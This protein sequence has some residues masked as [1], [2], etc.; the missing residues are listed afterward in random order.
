V[1]AEREVQQLVREHEDELVRPSAGRE[2]RVDDQAAGG[3]DAH[4]RHA[5]VE[6]DADR[7]RPAPRGTGS[8]TVS[9]RRPRWTRCSW[10]DWRRARAP[11][12]SESGSQV[13][14][15]LQEREH[16]LVGA[17]RAPRLDEIRDERQLMLGGQAA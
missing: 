12:R 1:R 3:E 2:R 13:G 7:W 14:H 5:I 16:R 8:G 11:P 17:Q 10:S 6:R 4:R 9:S 15:L